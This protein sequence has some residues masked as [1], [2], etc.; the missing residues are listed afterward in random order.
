[1]SDNKELRAGYL[2][3]MLANERD[4][5]HGTRKGYR[6]GC[7]CDRCKAAIS[8]AYFE[9]KAKEQRKLA[10]PRAFLYAFPEHVRAAG[11][12]DDMD[13]LSQAERIR[14]EVG[15]LASAVS[16]GEGTDRVLEECLD[17]VHACETLLRVWPAEEVFKARNAVVSKN[18]AR[19][20][21]M[22]KGTRC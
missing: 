20:Y 5:R 22:R 2:R 14:D 11:L 1:M 17:V 12:R 19:G 3:E 7:R 4:P 8:E 9:G 18:D 16:S 15:E 13:L 6:Y 10:Q 21:Y